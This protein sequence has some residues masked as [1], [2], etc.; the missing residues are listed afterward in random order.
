VAAQPDQPPEDSPGESPA[1]PPDQPAQAPIQAL[2]IP[3]AARVLG[4]SVVTIRR[5]LK[6]GELRG[7]RVPTPA[8]F[9]WRI[10]LPS[11]LVDAAGAAGA[12]QAT[13]QGGDQGGPN[14]ETAGADQRLIEALQAQNAELRAELAARRRE[15]Q[16]LHVLL[17]R[18]QPALPPPLT[19]EAVADDQADQ[20][21]P[22]HEATTPEE[23]SDNSSGAEQTRPLSGLR[24]L[25]QMITGG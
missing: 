6:R 23:S 25:W 7:Q 3:E 17:A 8:G 13:R 4:L 16:E 15:V 18:W 19:G 9:E 5:R 20:A 2:T 21:P 1:H 11:P 10:L 12:D 24:R 22:D 14:Q